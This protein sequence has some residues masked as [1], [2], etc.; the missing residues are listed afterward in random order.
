MAWFTNE[1]KTINDYYG[2]GMGMSGREEA[3]FFF[4]SGK[5]GV[6]GF[7]EIYLFTRL[8]FIYGYIDIH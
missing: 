7:F 4:L 1:T 5:V 6:W 8:V 3:S 2:E